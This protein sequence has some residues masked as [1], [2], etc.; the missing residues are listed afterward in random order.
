MVDLAYKEFVVKSLNRIL[1]GNGDYRDMT[2][3]LKVLIEECGSAQVQSYLFRH[4]LGA[5]DATKL[6]S[7][8]ENVL[9]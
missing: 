4:E 2:H 3:I 6:H 5:R 1:D 9:A 8:F 7:L